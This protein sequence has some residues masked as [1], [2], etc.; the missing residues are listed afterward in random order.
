MAND[1]YDAL[2][3]GGGQG[4]IPLAKALARAGKRVALAERK[5]L[6]GSCVNFGCT[7]TKAAIAS[8][9]VASLARRGAEFG[10]R[11]PV[12]EVDF[13]RVLQRAQDIALASRAALQRSLDFSDNPRLIHGHARFVGRAGEEFRVAIDHQEILAGQVILDTGTRSAR[14]AIEGIDEIDFLSSENW[15]AHRELPARLVI[16]G[17]GYIGLE[18]GQFYR[19][20][21]SAVA[22][23]E[24]SGQIVEHEDADVAAALQRVLEAEGIRFH[25]NAR[26]K[27]FRKT[28]DGVAVTLSVEGKDKEI[29]A[30]N[31]F[32]ALGR[33]PNTDQLGLESIGVELSPHGTIP[34]D[35]RLAT[36]VPGVWALGDIRGGPMF[37]HTS[38]DD[39]HILES[40]L[41]G[42]RTHTLVRIV[43]YAIFTDPELGRVGMT[44]REA[45]QKGYDLRIG[46]FEMRRNGKARELGETQG[47]IKIVT[48]ARSRKV[49]G[50]A[51]LA[52]EAAELVHLYVELM[53]ADVPYTVMERAVHI[54]PTLAEAAQ[55]AVASVH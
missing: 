43:P 14:P 42:D 45:R 54:H 15:L 12:V 51:V 20:M 40:Q 44:E 37:T 38:W 1:R 2:I 4:G 30:S 26:A 11:I 7:P 55:S 28:A 29:G 34:V 22:I 41:V 39:Y 19:R 21:G 8:A 48:D 13:P 27:R 32:L 49:L 31:L 25:L 53:N 5:H 3:I 17:G 24:S 23:V 18:M 10:L 33:K 35:K 52:T 50:A 36:N 47:F 46:N 16:V 9:R 6:G